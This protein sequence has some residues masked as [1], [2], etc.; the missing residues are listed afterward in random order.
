MAAAVP[1]VVNRLTGR[2]DSHVPLAVPETV[3]DVRVRPGGVTFYRR[4]D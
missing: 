3:N 1:R 2:T 4:I